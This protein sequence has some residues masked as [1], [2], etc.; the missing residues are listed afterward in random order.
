MR[1]YLARRLI[2]ALL[3]C[4]S[5][6]DAKGSYLAALQSGKRKPPAWLTPLPYKSDAPRDAKP[7]VFLVKP[8]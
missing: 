1:P 7:A 8:Q 6:T 3:I 2:Q 4:P 5:S